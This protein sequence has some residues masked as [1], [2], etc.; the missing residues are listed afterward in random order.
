MCLLNTDINLIRDSYP[1]DNARSINYQFVETRSSSTLSQVS[2]AI[3]D[4]YNYLYNDA[5]VGCYAYKNPQK[6]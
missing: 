4:T 1:L 2:I 3:S 6:C 5:A